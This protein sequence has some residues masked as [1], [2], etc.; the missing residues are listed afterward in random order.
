MSTPTRSPAELSGIDTAD[1]LKISPLRDDNVTH[2][3]PTWI[4][5][6]VLDGVFYGS[7]ARR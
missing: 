1:D 2:G 3:T 7:N 4:W 6:V 5:C